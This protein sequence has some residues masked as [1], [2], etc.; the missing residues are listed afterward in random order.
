MPSLE[1]LTVESNAASIFDVYA[2]RL[3]SHLCL[4]KY[5]SVL[6]R[7]RESLGE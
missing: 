7:V 3:Q 1:Y 5:L 6:R 2:I 4:Q